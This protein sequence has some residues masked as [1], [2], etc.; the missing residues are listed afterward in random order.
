[1]AMTAGQKRG[2]SFGNCNRNAF[3]Q[4]TLWNVR[5]S[6]PETTPSAKMKVP[7]RS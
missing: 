6:L 4:E 5:P 2:K 1:M 7:A 3:A